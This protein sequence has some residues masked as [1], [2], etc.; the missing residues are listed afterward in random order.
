MA[1]FSFFLAAVLELKVNS[2]IYL[3]PIQTVA[4]LD[5]SDCFDGAVV[6]LMLFKWQI[7]QGLLEGNAIMARGVTKSLSKM[8]FW[9]LGFSVGNKTFYVCFL[10]FAAYVRQLISFFMTHVFWRHH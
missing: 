5:V 8:S 7:Q 6:A 9:Q 1:I 4:Q 2:L 10:S 3:K